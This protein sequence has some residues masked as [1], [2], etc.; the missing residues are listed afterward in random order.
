MVEEASGSMAEFGTAEVAC[1]SAWPAPAGL[2]YDLASAG[3]GEFMNLI[4]PLTDPRAHGGDPADGFHVVAPSPPGFGF[5]TPVR[6]GC[7]LASQGPG[8]S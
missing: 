1:A 5:S 8:T 4:G 6:D 7:C 3:V 2:T